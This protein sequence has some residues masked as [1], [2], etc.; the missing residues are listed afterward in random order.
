[1]DVKERKGSEKEGKGRGREM[2]LDFSLKTIQI[3]SP[4][5]TCSPLLIPA[6]LL[7]IPVPPCWDFF[8]G[9]FTN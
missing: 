2:K 3:H 1:M 9:G 8:G 6:S 7:L 4:L 5:L